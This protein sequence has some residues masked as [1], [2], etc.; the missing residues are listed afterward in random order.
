[1]QHAAEGGLVIKM[2]HHIR[3]FREK[4]YTSLPALSADQVRLLR[5][6]VSGGLEEL[7][8]S[9]ELTEDDF[10]PH[11]SVLSKDNALLQQCVQQILEQVFDL[12]S[13]FQPVRK[14]PV[15]SLLFMKTRYNPYA[16][17]AHQDIAYEW[18]RDVEERGTLTTWIALDDCSP[19]TSALSFLPG[20]H[21]GPVEEPEDFL[22]TDFEDRQFSEKWK[23]AA[24]CLTIRAGG[25][26]VFDCRTWHAA[27]PLSEETVRHGIVIRWHCPEA[28]AAT[29]LLRPSISKEEFGMYTSGRL[30]REAL[31]SVLGENDSDLSSYECA[32]TFLELSERGGIQMSD[33]V[34][35]SLRVFLR[36]RDFFEDFHIKSDDSF[37]WSSIRDTAIPYLRDLQN[38]PK[39]LLS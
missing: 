17:H 21:L 5:T 22:R 23:E 27:P 13:L 30:F 7:R 15:G 25:M 32:K 34:E 33:R 3:E 28:A 35:K 14:K 1:M 26:V 31:L 24:E 10:Y 11:V 19:M 6:V 8:S 18:S 4:G 39:K 38:N 16:T 9:E 2:K 37:V 29:P 20:S 36:A 12:V